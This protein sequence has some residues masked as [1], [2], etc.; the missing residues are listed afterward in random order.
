MLRAPC[1][2]RQDASLTT[3]GRSM[4][5]GSQETWRFGVFN[6][7]ALRLFKTVEERLE[8][9]LGL[10]VDV[11][12]ARVCRRS[13]P[14]SSPLRDDGMRTGVRS[15]GGVSNGDS[16]CEVGQRRSCGV[17]GTATASSAA[18]NKCSLASDF[19]ASPSSCGGRGASCAVALAQALYA[20]TFLSLGV[21]G[22]NSLKSRRRAESLHTRCAGAV[23]FP[24]ASPCL[25]IRHVC[26]K[27]NRALGL[28]ACC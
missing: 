20:A 27:T 21:F 25:H 13:A 10:G 23:C 9:A 18:S 16:S 11:A 24:R 1:R 12:R 2:L 15:V 17:F 8:A 7:V 28:L 26:A 5:A 14:S 3:C 19:L 4:V 22:L 6:S